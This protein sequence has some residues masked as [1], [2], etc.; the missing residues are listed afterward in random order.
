MW[1][2]RHQPKT[3]SLETFLKNTSQLG[4]KKLQTERHQN[5]SKSRARGD[6]NELNN[7]A[8]MENSILR[9]KSNENPEKLWNVQRKFCWRS[10]HKYLEILS[11]VSGVVGGALRNDYIRKI[12]GEQGGII[13]R[14]NLEN[15]FMIKNI[16]NGSL[17][18]LRSALMQGRLVGGNRGL[19]CN[20]SFGE[21]FAPFHRENSIE[22]SIM[23]NK[24][25][26]YLCS[27]IGQDETGFSCE[28]YFCIVREFC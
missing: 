16:Q 24:L 10:S 5:K 1:S 18:N 23:Q 11:N 20:S 6:V 2:W 17:R 14:C 19:K 21:Y 3:S 4:W 15:Y 22:K 12:E 9:S 26:W 13:W 27:F 8:K 25:F 7:C 28:K